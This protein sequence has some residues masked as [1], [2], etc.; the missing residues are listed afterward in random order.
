MTTRQK[1]NSIA[2]FK[3]LSQLKGWVVTDIV[4]DGGSAYTEE[5]FGLQMENGMTAWIQCDPEGNGPG[6]LEIEKPTKV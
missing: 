1:E 4:R 3:H 6:F 2:M 5:C